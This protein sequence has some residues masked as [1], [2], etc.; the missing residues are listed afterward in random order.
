M[1]NKKEQK[2]EE[3]FIPQKSPKKP[4]EVEKGFV[5]PTPPKKPPQKPSNAKK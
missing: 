5:P 1:P 2:V 4:E 3:G